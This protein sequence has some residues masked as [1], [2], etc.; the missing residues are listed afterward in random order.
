MLLGQIGNFALVLAFCLAVIQSVLP[1]VGT[2]LADER[3]MRSGRSLAVG[4]FAFL[5]IAYL[6][7]TWAFI[8]DDFSLAYV[9]SN[10]AQ[11]LPL[12]YKITA[13]WGGHE[14]SMLFWV[15]TLGI[16]GVAVATF[17][18]ALPREM[19]ARVL[20]VM[21]MVGVGFIGFTVFTSN[22]FDTLFPIPPE[23]TD[24]NPL[25]QDPGMIIHPP[26]LFIGYTGLA[27]AFAFA[28]AALIGGRLDAAWA[29]WSRPWTTAAWGFLTLGIGL[30]SWWAYYELGW[31]GWWFWDPVENASLLPWLTATAL[32]HS[33]AVTEK[34]G[35]FKVWTVML[36]I[37][38]FALTIFG[39]FLVRSGVITSVHAFATDPDRGVFILGLLAV[40]LLGSLALY[41]WRAPK[42]GLGGAFS[43][44]SRESLLLANN[45]LL[46]VACAAVLVGT[47]YPVA[48]DALGLGKISVGPPYFDAVFMPLMLPLLFLIGIGPLVSWKHSSPYETYRQL[49]WI[50]LVCVVIGGLWPLTMGA[51][52][53]LTAI[54]LMIVVWILTTAGMDFYKRVNRRLD[55]G[56]GPAI[57]GALRPNFFG[58]HAAHAGLALIV[59]AIAMVNTYEVE[60]DVRLEPGQSEM[61]RDYEF[62]MTGTSE[63]RGANFT[64]Q[65]A[66]IEVRRN[67]RV[68]NTLY[69]QLRYYD[70]S[71]QQPMHQASLDRGLIR[72]V[73]V[74]LGDHLGGEAW[75]MRLY[76]KP[77]MTWMW[78][79]C[80]LMAF[81]GFLAAGDRRYRMQGD[82]RSVSEK[83]IDSSDNTV[84]KPARSEVG[85]S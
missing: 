7:L 27:V 40:T 58:M 56:W 15:L 51:W 73:Y 79:G 16:W 80:L 61:V 21:G 34:R 49:R 41:A 26:L 53:P 43:W 18:R 82:R 62:T 59:M 10:S 39:G 64:A 25:L 66:E 28:M 31:G 68:I 5:L 23:G 37:V 17:S 85:N 8:S 3:L 30:G 74:A 76:Y 19:L 48:V 70:K 50:F 42:V 63:V 9:Y 84:K 11:D 12:V 36:A 54:G 20:A 65:Q 13:V 71:P 1:L 77:Y 2:Y 46:T 22:P 72:D 32:I 29:R 44:Y 52:N 83:N 14:G 47:L 4:Q 67:G 24:L 45:V 6:A 81:G 78:A 38:S 69:P 75:T 55:M 35:G 33:L 57:R 60:R